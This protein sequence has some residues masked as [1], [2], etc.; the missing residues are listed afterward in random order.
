M[1]MAHLHDLDDG[2]GDH[3]GGP[4]RVVASGHDAVEE[5][6]ALAELHDEVHGIVVLVG[7]PEGDD[8]GVGREVAHDLDLAAHVLDVHRRAQLLLGDGLAGE[9]LAAGAVRAEVGDPELAPPQLPAQLVPLRD[10]AARGLPEDDE[11]VG[12]GGGRGG[13]VVVDGEGVGFGPL[14]LLRR[15]VRVA[16]AAAA[17]ADA[18][19]AH[20]PAIAGVLGSESG[21]EPPGPGLT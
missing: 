21:R 16:A 18:A 19:V 15:L 6:A 1:L 20:L 13:A 3:S 14:L 12:G 8:V 7:V 2:L 10:V 5:L 4:L 17:A 9:R 11:A